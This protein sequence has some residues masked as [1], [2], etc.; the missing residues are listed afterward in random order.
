MQYLTKYR[1]HVTKPLP[2]ITMDNTTWIQINKIQTNKPWVDKSKNYNQNFGKSIF[3]LN[4][5]DWNRVE[6]NV[7]FLVPHVEQEF[8][9][10]S[11]RTTNTF[12]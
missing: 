11:D 8:W 4:D 6:T 12:E 1:S 5:A 2:G 9:S 10:K 7:T 3:L